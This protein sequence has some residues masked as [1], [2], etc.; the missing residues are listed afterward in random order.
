MIQTVG[1]RFEAQGLAEVTRQMKVL[2]RGINS[3]VNAVNKLETL[4]TS[5]AITNLNRLA[6]GMGNAASKLMLASNEINAA[7]LA[8]TNA[9]AVMGRSKGGGLVGGPGGNKR[10]T[11]SPS[12]AD[13]TLM[14]TGNLLKYSAGFALVYGAKEAITAAMGKTRADMAEPSFRLSGVGIKDK[15]DKRKIEKDV[16]EF[17]IQNPYMGKISEGVAGAAEMASAIPFGD[18]RYPTLSIDLL[19]KMNRM[20]M[21]YSKLAEMTPKQAADSG[22]LSMN[23]IIAHKSKA[24]QDAYYKEPGKLEDLYD[25][26]LG[27]QQKAIDIS[28]VTGQD[29]A[30][31]NKHALPL[32]L[33]RGWNYES[34]LAVAAAEKDIGLRVS[35]GGRAMKNLYTHED[36]M[37]LLMAL[38]S[39]DEKL[40]NKLSGMKKKEQ[41]EEGYRYFQQVKKWSGGDPTKFLDLASEAKSRAEGRGINTQ[42]LISAEFA[43]YIEELLNK[44]FI[45]KLREYT[46]QIGKD[47]LPSAEREK[48]VKEAQEQENPLWKRLEQ[49]IDALG[50][51]IGDSPEGSFFGDMGGIFNGVAEAAIFLGNALAGNQEVVDAATK[52]WRESLNEWMGA[53][54]KRYQLVQDVAAWNQ[55][56]D[57]IIPKFRW[58][59][60]TLFDRQSAYEAA[61]GRLFA[62]PPSLNVDASP[63]LR[64]PTSEER[65]LL[66]E[67]KGEGTLKVTIDFQ[68]IPKSMTTEAGVVFGNTTGNSTSRPQISQTPSGDGRLNPTVSQ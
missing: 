33:S 14:T 32:L 20:N 10:A 43:Q 23:A 28:K 35:S 63:G 47:W 8:F 40:F 61:G 48:L 27:M 34:A 7:T 1:I 9:N 4:N 59:P 19:N 50:K 45:E 30:E 60:G 67:V 17:L 64:A 21:V 56:K 12:F 58:K 68:N 66:H 62:N 41:L 29:I 25:R 54:D 44:D 55:V 24:E 51:F 42:K 6:T 31:F 16:T 5:A 38:G 49:R 2:G 39:A 13:R 18:K 36:K 26:I 3:L 11:E 46:K 37:G 57:D 15:A 22:V 53:N 52:S 65:K